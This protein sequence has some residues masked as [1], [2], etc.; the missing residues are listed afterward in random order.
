MAPPFPPCSQPLKS[1]HYTFDFAQMVTPPHMARQPGPLY[2]Q[3]PRKVQLFGVC[4]EGIP[5]QVNYLLDEADTIGPNGTKSYGANTVASLLHDFFSRHG[6]GESECV[7]HADNCGGQNKNC[8]IVAYLAWRVVVGLHRKISLSFMVAGHTRCLVDGCFG[9][10]KQ[11][12]RQ[13]DVYTL[14]QLSEVVNSSAMCNV[15]VVVDSNRMPLYDLGQLSARPL[16]ATEM[17]HKVLPLCLQQE[18]SR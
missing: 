10:L 4:S 17:H 7:L 15:S 3:T 18:E 11:K 13:S 9:L 14:Q 5:K 16:Q 8:T 2:F 12:F 6:H 1:V